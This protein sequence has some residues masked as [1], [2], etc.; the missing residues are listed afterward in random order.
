MKIILPT[1]GVF[2]FDEMEA[3]VEKSVE[4]NGK[5]I[6]LL[7]AINIDMNTTPNVLVFESKNPNYILGDNYVTIGNLSKDDVDMV[8]DALANG[9]VV[10]FSKSKFQ[11]TN[12]QYINFI[13]DDGASAPYFYRGLTSGV[14]CI[15]M[16]HSPYI[17]TSAVND[18]MS[19]VGDAYDDELECDDY[20]EEDYDYDYVTDED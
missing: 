3:F 19:N 20:E 4:F 17:R 2:S 7:D 8:V 10:D 15:N 6:V 18:S 14:G 16:A 1:K 5:T 13:R 11:P 12:I 9:D